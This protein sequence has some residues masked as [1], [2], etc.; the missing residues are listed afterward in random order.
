MSREARGCSSAPQR[1]SA[2]ASPNTMSAA[3]NPDSATASVKWSRE[4]SN[5][6]FSSSSLSPGW[7]SISLAATSKKYPPSYPSTTFWSVTRLLIENPNLTSSHLFRAD[8]LH[9]SLGELRTVSELEADYR[10]GVA[11]A[12][13]E[14]QDEA[15]SGT[16]RH[17]QGTK[18][19]ILNKA[20]NIEPRPPKKYERFELWRTVVRRLVPR[21]PNLDKALD[22]TV[23]FYRSD[24]RERKDAKYDL[25]CGICVS[26]PTEEREAG[27]SEHV[28]GCVE[29]P[30]VEEGC[31]VVFTPHMDDEDGM[32]WYHPTVQALA[33]VYIWMAPQ[34]SQQGKQPPA[35]PPGVDAATGTFSLHFLPFHKSAATQSPRLHRTAISLLTTFHRLANHPLSQPHGSSLPLSFCDSVACDATSPLPISPGKDTLFPR[36]RLQNTYTRLK[37][38]HASSL[39]SKWVEKT[40]PS[41]HV[42]EDLGIAAFLIELWRSMYGVCPNYELAEGEGAD[43]PIGDFPGFV[44][45]ACG[46]GVLTHILIESGYRGYGFDARRRKTWDEVFPV[47]TRE[48]LREKICIPAPF[49]KVLRQAGEEIE[50]GEGMIFDG[51]CDKGMFIISNHADELTVWTPLLAA[52]SVPTEPLPFLAIPCCSHALNGARHRYK[53]RKADSAGS[54]KA[55]TLQTDEANQPKSGD[56]KALKTHKTSAGATSTYGT[57]TDHTVGVAKRLGY[58]PETTL[59]R[60]P[61]TRNVGIVCRQWRP[62]G[63]DE[64]SECVDSVEDVVKAVVEEE[65]GGG[66]EAGVLDAAKVWMEKVSGLRK[67]PG[68]GKVN[69]HCERGR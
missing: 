46:N 50:L 21:N 14:E 62:L 13:N 64:A 55:S 8:I 40:E 48:H 34:S 30:S 10:C 42:F 3:C 20:H 41:K 44:D 26:L 6:Y 57:L 61:S 31:L 19:N 58:N 65:C 23:H 35:P 56:L 9:D 2:L 54:I 12:S 53:T 66:E 69:W 60:I 45:I 22:Q 16:V 36:H 18:L 1:A 25:G 4:S 47:S 11:G 67:G 28:E 27:R 59:L 29:A 63:H 17:A 24:K 52:M 43:V 7:L 15:N 38:L 51:T 68:R 32:P 39:I 33:F 37:L 49:L 5:P